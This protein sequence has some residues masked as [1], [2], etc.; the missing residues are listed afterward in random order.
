[1]KAVMRYD[2]EKGTTFVEVFREGRFEGSFVVFR[3]ED[4]SA[5][6]VTVDGARLVARTDD[7]TVTVLDSRGN[8]VGR[9]AA[10]EADKYLN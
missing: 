5:Q 4:G 6:A 10:K 3:A 8:T 9:W 2:R 1:M 7:S